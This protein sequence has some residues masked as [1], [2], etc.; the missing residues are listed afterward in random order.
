MGNETVTGREERRLRWDS[1]RRPLVL[2]SLLACDFA[3]MHEVLDLLEGASVAGVHL[4]V[5]DGH[6]VPNLTYGPPVIRRWR[7]AT[8]LFFDAHLMVSD[9]ARYL[10]DYVAAGCDRITFHIEAVPDPR[11]L[12]DRIRG[13]GCKPCLS[14]NP[15]TPVDRVLPWIEHVDCVLV[16]S[17]MPGFGGQSFQPVALE[18]VEAL[19]RASATLDIQID[20]GLN[21]RTIGP[22][23]AAGVTQVVAGSAVFAQAGGEVGAILAL[24]EAA[25]AALSSSAES[26]RPSGPAPE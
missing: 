8:G 23:I 11:D 19:R 4:D 12:L 18:K 9:P 20:G 10:D 25:R 5:M 2:P 3:R 7:E 1:R 14:L 26:E 15:P 6:F 21:L 16:M 17:V 22:A 24:E 13:A